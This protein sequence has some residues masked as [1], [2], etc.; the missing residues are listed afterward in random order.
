MQTNLGKVEQF[1][2]QIVA[3]EKAIRT[4]VH[5]GF[6]LATCP[7]YVLLGDEL[8]SPRG[9][10]YQMKEMLEQGGP[11]SPETV[12]HVDRCLS[13]L[14]CMT[15]CPSGVNYMRLVD[16]ARAYIE[17]NH[18]RP[19]M[20]RVMR[21]FLAFALPRRNLFRFLLK[22]SPLGKPFTGLLP[23]RLK[24]MVSM[25]PSTMPARHASETPQVFPA[26]GKRKGRI[27]ILIGCAQPVLA[28]HINETAIRY[29]NRLGMDVVVSEGVGCC[30][31]L[32][33][34]LGKVDQSHEMAKANIKAWVKEIEGEGLD[35]IMVT[36][37]G[38]GTSLK[39]YGFMFSDDPE[40]SGPASKVA[41]ISRDVSEVLTEMAFPLP[42]D[43]KRGL[44]VAYQSACSL[45]HGQKITRE[46]VQLLQA[47]GYKVL[48][49]NEKH[50]CCGS[51]GTYN[52]LQPEIANQLRDRKV[53]SLESLKPDVIA[54]GNLGCMA[55]VSQG[56]DIPVVHTLELLDWA[57]GG[58]VPLALRGSLQ[59]AQEAA[60]TS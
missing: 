52:I 55:Q 11:P 20:D 32:P 58:P 14:A 47:A 37:S 46:P 7:T 1:D 6:C 40:W 34:H 44:V 33:H 48:E 4:C 39:D 19:F 9:R 25:A 8:D 13:C 56:T 36:T 42:V 30:G 57:A 21:S 10:I 2:P 24:A 50:L 3:S 17:E 31:A 15:T 23:G 45:Q 53:S 28:P 29:F 16:H 38:C 59:E 43:K 41:A 22:L 54:T 26:Q 60:S 5:C 12:K 51:A 49:P 18:K 35:T 27:A